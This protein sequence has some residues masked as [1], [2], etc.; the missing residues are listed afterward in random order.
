MK[1]R[2]AP[3]HQGTYQTGDTPQFNLVGELG[4]VTHDTT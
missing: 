1:R 4:M 3:G 2:Q